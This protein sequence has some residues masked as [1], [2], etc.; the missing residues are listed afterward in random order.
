[1]D[2]GPMRNS[3]AGPTPRSS[4]VRFYPGSREHLPWWRRTFHRIEYAFAALDLGNAARPFSGHDVPFGANMAIRSAEQKAHRYDPNLGPRPDRGLRGEEITL[5]KALLSAGATG[6]WVPD[7]RV[8]HY[9]PKARQTI[10][11]VRGWYHGWGEYL[12]LVPAQPE[13]R[14]LFGRP[15]WLWREMI[16]SELTFRFRRLLGQPETWIEDLKTAS[17]ARGRFTH[18]VAEAPETTRA[19]TGS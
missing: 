15:L 10:A 6:W 18:S 17:V 5:V 4:A 9:I 2:R 14:R 11:Y 3:A 12:A 19:G 1:M 16:A 7:A 8:R 13:P